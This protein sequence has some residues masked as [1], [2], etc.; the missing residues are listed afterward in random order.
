MEDQLKIV[1]TKMTD[2]VGELTQLKNNRARAEI[3]AQIIR[4]GMFYQSIKSGD[5]LLL[6]DR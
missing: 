5:D 1:G 2:L 6:Q 4:L 3:I